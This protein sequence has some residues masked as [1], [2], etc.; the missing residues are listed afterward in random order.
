MSRAPYKLGDP[1][2]VLTY[3]PDHGTILATRPVERI[4][5]SDTNGRWII[6]W[7]TPTG[8]VEDTTVDATGHD[9]HR[10]IEPA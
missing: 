10:Y 9:I 2:R 8:L 1:I 3:H 7:T 6:T 4:R 5:E